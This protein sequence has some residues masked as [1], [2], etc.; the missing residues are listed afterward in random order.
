[1]MNKTS[2]NRSTQLQIPLSARSNWNLS[3]LLERLDN[4]T[5]FLGELLTVFR[6]DSQSALQ[7]AK[8]AFDGGNLHVLEHK[9]HTLKGMLRNLMMDR[10]AHVAAALEVAA[11]QQNTQQSASLLA[12]LNQTMEALLP[13]VDAQLAEFRK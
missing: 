5:V 3:E 8:D 10:A 7:E 12:E 13:E 2:P 4:D 9:A 11:R 1:M 6:V